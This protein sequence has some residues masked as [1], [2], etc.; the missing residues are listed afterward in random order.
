MSGAP[1]TVI[2]AWNIQ[3]AEPGLFSCPLTRNRDTSQEPSCSRARPR[4]TMC[5]KYCECSGW[6]AILPSTSFTLTVPEQGTRWNTRFGLP[7]IFESPRSYRAQAQSTV[8]SCVPLST[9]TVS[10]RV[11]GWRLGM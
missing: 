10:P 3:C 8:N 4:T 9:R 6:A 2:D 1:V 5:G 7:S 11:D